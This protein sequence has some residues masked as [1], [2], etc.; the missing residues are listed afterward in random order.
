MLSCAGLA[1]GYTR[2]YIINNTG[3]EVFGL[4]VKL[5][6]AA[7]PGSA[8]TG[9]QT[10]LFANAKV[11]ADGMTLDFTMPFDPA[12]IVAGSTIWIG[13]TDANP[14][15]TGEIASFYF[16]DGAGNVVGG[17]QFPTAG[18]TGALLPVG[19]GDP[20]LPGGGALNFSTT[21]SGGTQ[22]G[23]VDPN[24]GPTGT[25]INT[26][27]NTSGSGPQG[28]TQP[29][30]GPPSGGGT[31]LG[32]TNASVSTP[33]PSSIAMLGGGILLLWCARRKRRS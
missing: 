12:G 25:Q 29:N 9:Q 3:H 27:I 19:S 11:S 15:F 7:L 14:N 20:G 18:D 23:G 28:G 2:A 24:S 30:G 6:Q 26:Q 33:E 17:V 8:G 16:D 31:S 10:A 5:T 22:N 21:G 13:W 1:H 32:L 4:H